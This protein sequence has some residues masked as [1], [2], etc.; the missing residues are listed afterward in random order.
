MPADSP[1]NKNYIWVTWITGLLAG[2]CRCEYAAWYKAHYRYAKLPR[3]DGDLST[4]K[5]DHAEMLVARVNA[6]EADGWAVKIEDEN[7]FQLKGRTAILAG[8]PDLVA[9]RGLE[10][11]VVDEKSGEPKPEHV[12]QVLIY[13]YALQRVDSFVSAL[14][15]AL[16]GELEYR[17]HS[18]PVPLAQLDTQ[19]TARITRTIQITAAPDPP[20]TTASIAEC[21]WCDIKA[22]ADRKVAPRAVGM[23]EAF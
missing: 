10:A 6:L 22:C 23:T 8:K 15:A 16:G 19:A 14:D 2:S 1:R 4:W 11:I 12:W 5:K 3:E 17:G 21:L 13:L 9:T 20:P 7:A 18:V